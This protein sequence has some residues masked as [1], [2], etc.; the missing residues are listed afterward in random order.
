MIHET[1]RPFLH[2]LVREHQQMHK[3]TQTLR[4]KLEQGR[5][6]G[7]TEEAALEAGGALCQLRNY[8]TQHFAHEE[9]DGCFEDAVAIMPTCAPR[10]DDLRE[11]HH[12]ILA[13]L[14]RFHDAADLDDNRPDY[15][16]LFAGQIEELLAQLGNHEQREARL[17]AEVFNVAPDDT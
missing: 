6:H 5:L 12:E 10:I 17:I 9:E 8:A 2:D 11:E 13:A 1:L 15:W 3:L 16:N 14:D 7:W 4:D